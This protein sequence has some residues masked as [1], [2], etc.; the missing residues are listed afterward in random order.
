MRPRTVILIALVVLVA[1]I[2]TPVAAKK[3]VEPVGDL[4]KL[5]FGEPDEF[6]VRRSSIPAD[7]AFHIQHGHGLLLD[8]KLSDFRLEILM[9]GKKLHADSV[10]ISDDGTEKQWLFNFSEGLPAGEYILEGFWTYPC[11]AAVDFGFYGGPCPKPNERWTWYGDT[12]SG[13]GLY[14]ILTI[15]P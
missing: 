15:G 5:Y 4:H 8:Y 12:P 3:T 1:L 14:Q 9:D 6:G 13:A 2:A 7:T 11:G 10:F